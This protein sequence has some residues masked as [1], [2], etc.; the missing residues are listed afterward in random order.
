MCLGLTYFLISVIV[1]LIKKKGATNGNLPP[2]IPNLLYLP[3]D[4]IMQSSGNVT[5][6]PLMQGTAPGAAAQLPAS[7][8]A[9]PRSRENLRSRERE[10]R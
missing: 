6:A 10:T 9:D 2:T 7:T 8:A 3:L 4:K 5:A 1:C